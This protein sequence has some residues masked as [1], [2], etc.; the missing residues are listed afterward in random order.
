M[1]EI[2]IKSI[3]AHYCTLFKFVINFLNIFEFIVGIVIRIADCRPI[4]RLNF[5][6][7]GHFQLV[8]HYK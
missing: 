3:I 6:K 2:S 1:L 7:I 8:N 5:V 4:Y